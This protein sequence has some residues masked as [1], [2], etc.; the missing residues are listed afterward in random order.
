MATNRPNAINGENDPRLGERRG[1]S[2][3]IQWLL[4][5][6]YTILCKLFGRFF[7]QLCKLQEQACRCVVSPTTALASPADCT[8][9]TFSEF[10]PAS[11]TAAYLV[12]IRGKAFG[13]S[14][15]GYKLGYRT[16]SSGAFIESD[17]KIIYPNNQ[18]NASLGAGFFTTPVGSPTING[19]LG[20]L[21]ASLLTEGHYEIQIRVAVGGTT[22]VQGFDLERDYV[23]IDTVNGMVIPNP[24][25]ENSQIP[26]AAGGS[27]T[28]TGSA[29]SGGCADKRVD[30]FTLEF[31]EG[32]LSEAAIIALPPAARTQLIL[33]VDYTTDPVFATMP[34]PRLGELTIRIFHDTCTIGPFTFDCGKAGSTPW[35]STV[36]GAGV[37]NRFNIPGR[38]GR[39]TFLLTV[40]FSDG[41]TAHESQ[42]VWLDNRIPVAWINK[43]LQVQSDG[44]ETDVSGCKP[45]SKAN[46]T[47]LR[48]KG[49]ALDPLILPTPTQ[50]AGAATAP[51]NNFGGYSVAYSEDGLSTFLPIT[52]AGTGPIGAVGINGT[53]GQ[54]LLDTTSTVEAPDIT[55][56]GL[57]AEWD[58]SALD[59]CAYVVKLSVNDM[60]V[61]SSSGNHTNEFFYALTI[62]A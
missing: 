53:T 12:E 56:D 1:C 60:T 9:G 17:A 39:H 42:Q 62:T 23:E 5:W 46:G 4:C 32:F 59:P 8:E 7:P 33:P 50:A 28:I 36:G 29:D 10:P 48:L 24:A 21:N 58:I 40:H 43:I 15:T 54:T 49:V 18:T 20:H 31:A 47:R 3:I 19:V 35:D 41:T 13:G 37:T 2:C 26:G 30:K 44:T 38:N 61:V 34:R 52:A 45:I 25:D 27:I 16:G 11:G 22:R 6:I 55:T 14:F 51:N 57:L